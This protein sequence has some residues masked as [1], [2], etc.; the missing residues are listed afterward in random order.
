MFKI[1]TPAL[2]LMK[3]VIQALCGNKTKFVFIPNE[4]LKQQLTF[5][6]PNK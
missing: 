6:E 4:K 2:F 5:L 3:L 1:K